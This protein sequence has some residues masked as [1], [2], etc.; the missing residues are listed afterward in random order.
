MDELSV[1]SG[2]T[3]KQFAMKM[4]VDTV[5]TLQRQGINGRLSKHVLATSFENGKH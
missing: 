4:D 5:I 1:L 2:K 3:W